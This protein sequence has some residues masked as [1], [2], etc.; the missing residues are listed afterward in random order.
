MDLEGECPGLEV[1]FADFLVLILGLGGWGSDNLSET[2]VV[3]DSSAL[4]FIKL[5]FDVNVVSSN[6]T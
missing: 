2:P 6:Q 1:K 4:Y 5:L 3:L